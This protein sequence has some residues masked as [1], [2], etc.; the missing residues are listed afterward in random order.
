MGSKRLPVV[1]AV[2]DRLG[3]RAAVRRVAYVFAVTWFISTA[4]AAQLAG[5]ND[6]PAIFD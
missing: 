4:M 5:L 6:H 3:R 1:E 2:V